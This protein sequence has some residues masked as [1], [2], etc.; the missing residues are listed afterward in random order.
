MKI[1]KNNVPIRYEK[2]LEDLQAKVEDQSATIAYLSMMSGID[3]P[4]K[5]AQNEP[6]I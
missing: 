6:E 4:Q 1:E 3:I 5:E 2:E